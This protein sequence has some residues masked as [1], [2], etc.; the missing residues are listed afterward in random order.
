[1]NVRP[2]ARHDAAFDVIFKRIEEVLPSAMM[3]GLF[4][5]PSLTPLSSTLF[6]IAISPQPKVVKMWLV[7]MQCSRIQIILL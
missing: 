3:G 7:T 5:F 2:A 6:S 1:M 4:D